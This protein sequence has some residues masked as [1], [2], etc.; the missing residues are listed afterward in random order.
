[1]LE[2]L[3]WPVLGLMLYATF[4]LVPLNHLRDAFRDGRFLAA[5]V[6]GNFVL[7]PILA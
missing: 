7:I 2:H 1:M 4:T 3:L 6:L 5:A